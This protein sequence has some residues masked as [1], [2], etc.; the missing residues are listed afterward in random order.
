MPQDVRLT[1]PETAAV[2][3]V[4]RVTLWR[5]IAAGT[6]PAPTLYFGRKVFWRKDVRRVGRERSKA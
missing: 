4:S 2:L 3:G 1:I 6:L 5:W